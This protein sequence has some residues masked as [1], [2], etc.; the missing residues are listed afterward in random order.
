M[1]FQITH[2]LKNG[3]VL[4]D[5]TGHII[6]QESAPVVYQIIEQMERE[7]TCEQRAERIEE[8]VRNCLLG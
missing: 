5:I 2:I 6:K 4:K 3:E 1:A 8:Q 7:G